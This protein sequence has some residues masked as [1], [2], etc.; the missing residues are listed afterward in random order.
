M[1]YTTSY[2]LIDH[3][4]FDN[5]PLRQGVL[6]LLEASEHIDKHASYHLQHLL[7]TQQRER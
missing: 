2:M 5:Q 4:E 6:L 1:L 7:I 3:M